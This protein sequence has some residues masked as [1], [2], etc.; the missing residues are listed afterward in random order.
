[1][2]QSDERLN[3]AKFNRERIFLDIHFRKRIKT[4]QNE[5]RIEK[6]SFFFKFYIFFF[7]LKSQKM[8]EDQTLQI[9]IRINKINW[10]FLIK[11]MSIFLAIKHKIQ[12]FLFY[13]FCKFLLFLAL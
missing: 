13:F 3:K 7:F 12:V 4:M 2:K 5:R 10:I 1:M 8:A 11:L 6:V 9:F